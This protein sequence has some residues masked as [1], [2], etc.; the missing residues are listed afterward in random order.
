MVWRGL[1]DE[2]LAGRVAMYLIRI[3]RAE[4]YE[5]NIGVSDA[6]VVLGKYIMGLDKTL[7]GLLKDLALTRT[8]RKKVEK[9]DVLVDVDRLLNS[10]ARKSE[11]ESK[12][13]RL[14]V[15]RLVL[16]DWTAEK[17]RLSHQ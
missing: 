11:V 12:A 6:T 15:Y 7:R 8:E 5:A 9:E 17:K 4:V 14:S 16:R 1:A 13:A 3:V 10:L 2:I